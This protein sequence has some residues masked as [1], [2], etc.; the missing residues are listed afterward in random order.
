MHIHY[1]LICF[2]NTPRL[3]IIYNCLDVSRHSSECINRLLTISYGKYSFTFQRNYL[4]TIFFEQI[5]FDIR[6]STDK[7]WWYGKGEVGGVGAMVKEK[8][9]EKVV[10][11]RRVSDRVMTAVIVSEEDVLRLICGYALQSGRR[12]EE[13]L[14]FMMS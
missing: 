5:T 14:S 12:L 6:G 9:C 2:I 4:F 8:L 3:K 11:V 13:K 7:L 1:I 10:E